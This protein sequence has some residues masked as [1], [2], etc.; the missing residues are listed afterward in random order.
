MC[1]RWVRLEPVATVAKS[2]IL[3][4][5]TE[6]LAAAPSPYRRAI[7]LLDVDDDERD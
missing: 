5:S 6:S 7:P 3:G 1:R 2:P 4:S